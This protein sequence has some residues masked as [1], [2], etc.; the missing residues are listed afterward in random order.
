MPYPVKMQRWSATRPF[1][2]SVILPTLGL[3]VC[4]F[5]WGLQYKLSLYDPPQSSS[6]NIPQA[7]L[8]SKAE[9]SGIAENPVAVGTITSARV[10]CVVP[11]AVF[12]FLLL[13]L[14]I[15]ITA[16]SGLRKQ[17]TNHPWHFRRGLL[18]IFFVRPPPI[19]AWCPESK[20]RITTE[21]SS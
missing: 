19:L 13:I 8:L 21:L 6:H 14:E 2:L 4:V 11:L 10:S 9:Q 7:K 16:A 5:A 3:A 15:S 17:C 12:F 1:S 18:N 20:V